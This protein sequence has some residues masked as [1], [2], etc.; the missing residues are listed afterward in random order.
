MFKVGDL[1]LYENKTLSRFTFRKSPSYGVVVSLYFSDSGTEVVEG[2][3][4]VKWFDDGK[5]P[6]LILPYLF[7]EYSC[8]KLV[9]SQN[10][11]KNVSAKK[12]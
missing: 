3:Y 11:E 12:R 4:F 5:E 7:K 10:G 2:A 1:I 8:F 6:E 9:A